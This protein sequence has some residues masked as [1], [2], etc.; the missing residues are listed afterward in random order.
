MTL[1]GDDANIDLALAVADENGYDAQRVSPMCSIDDEQ[2]LT[3]IELTDVLAE[4]GSHPSEGA[5]AA[6]ARAQR[7][8]EP[9]G[10]RLRAH[11]APAGRARRIPES[12]TPRNAD[13]HVALR[14]ASFE[15]WLSAVQAPAPGIVDVD[16]RRCV[17][18]GDD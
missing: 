18:T 16:G 10:F 9:L 14:S 6:L 8:L 1:S 7:I 17:V 5:G 12:A 13:T 3:W 4:F 11:G 2:T 15:A